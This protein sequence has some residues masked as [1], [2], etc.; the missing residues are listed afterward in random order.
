MCSFL[1]SAKTGDN[2]AK[3]FYR[4]VAD[5]AGVTVTSPEI[6]NATKVVTA[7]VIN[8]PQDVMCNHTSFETDHISIK[9]RCC[10]M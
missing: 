9:T 10:I 4:I 6:S 1:V 7:Q 2:V 3:V 8:H 5:L